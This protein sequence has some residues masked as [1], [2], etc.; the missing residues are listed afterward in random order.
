VAVAWPVSVPEPD[1]IV[2]LDGPVRMVVPAGTDVL[3]VVED[4]LGVVDVAGGTVLEA[5]AGAPPASIA[6][7][8]AAAASPA[9]APNL[10]TSTPTV[11]RGCQRDNLS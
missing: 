6:S 11:L 8:A 7:V 3:D 9:V 10:T 1:R 5:Y 2:V 4:V